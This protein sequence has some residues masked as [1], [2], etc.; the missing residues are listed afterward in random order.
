MDNINIQGIGEILPTGLNGIQAL[1]N[2]NSITVTW[3]MHNVQEGTVFKVQR[4]VNG[5]DFTTLNSIIESE[6]KTTNSY[7]YRDNHVPA[8]SQPLYYRVQGALSSGRTFLSPVVKVN[9]KAATQSLIGY[10]SVQ[11]QSLLTA[12][13]VPEKGTYHLSII[14]LNGAVVQQRAIELDAG[15]HVVTLPLQG[16]T[17]GTYVVRLANGTL[18]GSKKV[19]W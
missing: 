9:N 3:Q 2:E 16:V 5:V 10:A 18:T 19:V 13:Q 11:G 7:N 4:S 8:V 1:R 12:L 15:L 6:Y 17:H 14:S